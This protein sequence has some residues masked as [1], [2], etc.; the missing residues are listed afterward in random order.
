VRRI[1]LG[2][3]TVL[4]VLSVLAFVLA[5]AIVYGLTGKA[6]VRTGVPATVTVRPSPSSGS[7]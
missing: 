2:R 6:T 3:V 1:G 7:S 4:A 5:G